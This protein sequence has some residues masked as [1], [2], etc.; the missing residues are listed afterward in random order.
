MVYVQDVNMVL[1]SKVHKNNYSCALEII[2]NCIYAHIKICKMVHFR[3]QKEHIEHTSY[4]KKSS[5]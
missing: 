2:A 4:I 1:K 5:L 3:R